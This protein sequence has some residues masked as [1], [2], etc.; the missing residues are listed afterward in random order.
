MHHHTRESQSAL[1]W[2]WIVCITTGCESVCTHHSCHWD[3]DLFLNFCGSLLEGSSTKVMIHDASY[4]VTLRY[5]W[6]C[7]DH[8]SNNLIE[9]IRLEMFGSPDLSGFPGHSFEWRRLRLLMW[10][11]VWKCG[12]SREIVFDVY[13][14]SYENL[15][16]I[17]ALIM[18]SAILSAIS[19]VGGKLEKR[20][21]SR[22]TYIYK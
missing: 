11:S 19:S 4:V 6:I 10:K 5:V 22:T 3:F 15:L 20:S 1:P 21:R 18:L 8:A 2:T 7:L 9:E 16:Q 17:L 12:D 14:N 13:G